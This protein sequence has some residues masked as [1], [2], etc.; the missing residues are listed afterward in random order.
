MEQ[1]KTMS[2][3]FRHKYF[4]PG[5]EQTLYRHFGES[6]NKKQIFHFHRIQAFMLKMGTLLC[7]LPHESVHFKAFAVCFGLFPES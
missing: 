2:E 5:N 7:V 6:V 4:C 1:S 3:T